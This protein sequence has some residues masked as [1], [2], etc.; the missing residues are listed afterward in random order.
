LEKK[1]V[2]AVCCCMVFGP[3]A[4]CSKNPTTKPFSCGSHFSGPLA[5]LHKTRKYR[6]DEWIF[7]RWHLLYISRL[8]PRIL[9]W[10]QFFLVWWGWGGNFCAFSVVK[11]LRP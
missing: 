1:S 10:W 8:A 5:G 4:L 6:L 2:D 3:V 11:V 9:T 7:V